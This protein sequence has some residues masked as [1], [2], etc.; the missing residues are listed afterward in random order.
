MRSLLVILSA[1]TYVGCDMPRDPESTTLRIREGVLRAGISEHKPWTR[2]DDDQPRGVE[3]ELLED[4]ARQQQA[5]IRWVVGAESE[6]FEALR[7]G[8]LDIVIGG[9]D[10]S[11]PWSKE[12]AMTRPFITVADK[13]HVMAIRQ[14]E[15]RWLLELDRFL[16]ARSAEI[17]K[18]VEAERDE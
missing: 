4:F 9:L 6:L 18:L 1:V 15:N 13:K 12:I 2:F 14:G 11:T 3:V 10:D 5:E 16:Q 17:R 8:H 7:Q